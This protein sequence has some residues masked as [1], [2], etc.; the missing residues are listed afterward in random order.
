MKRTKLLHA[1][2]LMLALAACGGEPP[3]EPTAAESPIVDGKACTAAVRASIV[4][5]GL[6]TGSLPLLQQS[7]C[8]GTLIAPRLVL[9]ARHCVAPLLASAGERECRADGSANS[10][11]R[12][13]SASA[14]QIH[15]FADLWSPPLAR[16]TLALAP[17]ASAMCNGDVALLVLDRQ[18]AG[19]TPAPVRALMQSDAAVKRQRDPWLLVAGF[20]LLD[21]GVEN[22][23]GCQQRRVKVLATGA[24]QVPYLGR[25]ELVTDYGVCN[26]DSGGPVFDHAGQLVAV[27]SRGTGDCHGAGIYPDLAHHAALLRG[28]LAKAK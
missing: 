28:A 12:F 2:T 10:A 18:P 24:E 16:A 11:V 25:H 8:S 21:A 17:S 22:D 3:P 7:R 15:V 6:D 27:T 14:G 9:T 20:G 4:G 19:K 1:T 23:R 26:G 13:G 5:L